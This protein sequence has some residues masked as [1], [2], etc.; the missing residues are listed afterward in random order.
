MTLGGQSVILGIEQGLTAALSGSG[1]V[2]AAISGAARKIRA[3]VFHDRVESLGSFA[4]LAVY[5][6]CGCDLAEPGVFA[7]VRS[8]YPVDRRSGSIPV[9]VVG[10]CGDDVG[11]FVVVIVV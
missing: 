4:V 1:I 2:R 6:G 3:G 9:M 10:G 8:P 11:E 5:G 7:A